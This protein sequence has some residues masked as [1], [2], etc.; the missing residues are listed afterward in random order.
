[1]SQL[2]N[3]HEQVFV[4]SARTEHDL[5][6]LAAPV[7][8]RVSCADG[9]SLRSIA[10]TLQLGREPLPYR[11]GTVS[12]DRESL[13]QALREVADGTA[14]VRL[15]DGAEGATASEPVT[16][17]Q[18]LS[19]WLDGAPVDW[20]TLWSQPRPDLATLPTY[21]R[22]GQRFWP[23]DQPA[24]AAG[25]APDP[26]RVDAG[27]AA[28]SA[29]G[30]SGAGALAGGGTV[31]KLLDERWDQAQ[32]PPVR[33]FDR[34]V[35]VIGDAAHTIAPSPTTLHIDPT[36]PLGHVGVRA[37]AA[38]TSDDF[39]QVFSQ[40]S[41]EY[42]AIDAVVV[43][44]AGVA[45]PVET[46]ARV[47]RIVD[48][49][50]RLTNG[51]NQVVL[52]T[53]GGDA[54]GAAAN[55]LVGAARSLRMSLPASRVRTVSVDAASVVGGDVSSLVASELS[56][57][58]ADVRWRSGDRY[59]PRFDIVQ[60]GAGERLPHGVHLVFGGAGVL[61]QALAERILADHADNV[62]VLVGRAPVAV[63]E[64]RVRRLVRDGRAH[65]LQADVSDTDTIGLLREH[66]TGC[67]GPVVGL[68]LLA[69]KESAGHLWESDL[70]EVH[71]VLA[72]KI[73]GLEAVETVFGGDDIEVRCAFGSSSAFFGDMGGGDYAFANRYLVERARTLSSPW[74]VVS[75]P[76]WAGGGMGPSD[77]DEMRMYLGAS[78]QVPLA[79]RQGLDLLVKLIGL[80]EGHV[81]VLVGQEKRL[82]ALVESVGGYVPAYAT[83]RAHIAEAVNSVDRTVNGTNDA[84]ANPPALTVAGNK[85]YSAKSER[86]NIA[87][88]EGVVSDV[89]AAVLGAPVQE[90]L[91]TA[92]FADLGF[93]SVALVELATALEK[94]VGVRVTPDVFFGHPTISRLAPRLIEMGAAFNG[95]AMSESESLNSASDDAEPVTHAP[96]SPA[97][98][99]ARASAATDLSTAGG[100]VFVVGGGVRVGGGVCGFG[101]V[102]D[103]LV[104]GGCV[105]GGLGG[106]RG[107][108][109]SGLGF[110]GV[111]GVCG[112]FV[113]G[114][115]GFDP[116]FFEI[117]PRE[118]VGM[119]PRQRLLLEVAWHA[120]EDSGLT[121][122]GLSGCRVGVFVGAEEGDFQYFGSG[123]S[124]TSNSNAVLASRLSYF[125]GFDGPVVAVNTA[126]SSGLVAV[127]QGARAV[128]LGE[129]DV[130]VVGGVNVLLA[131]F[132]YEA[133]VGAG[134]VSSSGVCRAFSAEA[135][136][137][138]PGEAVAVVVLASAGVVGRLGLS[139]RVEVVGSGV[140]YDGR[141]NGITAPSGRAQ[142]ELVG[143][144]WA[145]AGVDAGS[146]G[147]VVAHG[148]GTRLGD[149][150][151]LN[152]LVSVCA[153]VAGPGCLV[154]SSKP[155]FGHALAA[156]GVV[157]LVGLVESVRRGVVPGSL[158]VGQGDVNEFVR[159][160]E[161]RVRV[162][163]RVQGWPGDPVVRRGGVSA[164][165]M[166]GTNAH[167]LVQSVVEPAGWSGLGGVQVVVVSAK[168]RAALRRRCCDIAGWLRGIVRAGRE[169]GGSG[170]GLFGAGAWALLYRREHFSY[171]VAVVADDP[172]TAAD[173]LE[174]T[175][176]HPRRWAGRVGAGFAPDADG[177]AAVQR[178][179]RGMSEGVPGAAEEVAAW[180]VAGYAPVED[181]PQ[182]LPVLELPGYPFATDTYWPTSDSEQETRDTHAAGSAY[183]TNASTFEEVVF[184]LEVPRSAELLADHVVVGSPVLSATAVLAH[185]VEA[186]VAAFPLDVSGVRVESV[187][188]LKPLR[189]GA[190][191]VSARLRFEPDGSALVQKFEVRAPDASVVFATGRVQAAE[192]LTE[193]VDVAA[194]R[195]ECRARVAAEEIYAA[196]E[197]RGMEY[198][199]TL[200]GLSE[201][202][203]GAEVAVADVVMPY[204]GALSKA[205]RWAAAWD[206]GLQSVIAFELADAT[207][208]PVAR[209]PFHVESVEM[210]VG[211]QPPV[212]SVLR[213]R[214]FGGRSTSVDVDMCAASGEV[215]ARFRGFTTV[216]V[217]SR[218]PG[219]AASAGD[220][221]VLGHM[222]EERL[223]SKA[224]RDGATHSTRVSL[225]AGLSGDGDQDQ[226]FEVPAS[227]RAFAET[228]VRVAKVLTAA[229]TDADV[230]VLV[231]AGDDRLAGWAALAKSFAM[232]QPGVRVTVVEVSN[233][234]RPDRVNELASIVDHA[235]ETHVRLSGAGVSARRVALLDNELRDAH[236]GPF[237]VEGGVY[238]ITGGAGALGLEVAE[239]LAESATHVVLI[240]RR[241]RSELSE[242]ARER[243]ER[244]SGRL[245]YVSVEV[246][247]AS[248]M[249][250]LVAGVV[251]G[252]GR[253]DGVIHAAGVL[254]EG[255]L[256]AADHDSFAR[257]ISPKVDGL[258]AIEAA[259]RDLRDV[260]VIAFT[261][262]AGVF[263]G[264]GQSAYAVANAAV[265]ACVARMAENRPALSIAWPLWAGGGMS[266]DPRLV[267]RMR[268]RSGLA[269]LPVPTGLAVIERAWSLGVPNVVC[270]Y[271]DAAKIRE[272][273]SGSVANTRTS[274]VT[275]DGAAASLVNDAAPRAGARPLSEIAFDVLRDALAP[276]LG[277]PWHQFDREEKVEAYGLDSIRMMS[278]IDAL[279]KRLGTL[280]RTLFFEHRT[281]DGVVE[282]LAKLAPDRLR[283]IGQLPTP[284]VEAAPQVV[285][286]P[287]AAASRE[288][289]EPDAA[290]LA[291]PVPEPPG[292][293]ATS[294]ERGLVLVE[295]G[296]QHAS[297][298]VTPQGSQVGAIAIVGMAGRYPQAANLGAFWRNLIEGKDCVTRV[299]EDRW[300]LSHV[301]ESPEQVPDVRGGFLDGVYEFDP[302]LFRIS[303]RDALLMEPQ[304]R[305]F[306]ECAYSTIENAGY[307]PFG[308]AV[309]RPVGVFVGVMYEEYQMLGAERQLLGERA[310]FTNTT[311]SIANRV[312]YAFEFTGPSMA[313]DTMC[314]SSLTAIHLACESIQRGECEQ[315]IAGGV[316]VSVHPAKFIMLHEQRFASTRGR[317]SSFGQ[318][319]DGYVPSE[320]VGAVLLKPLDRALADGDR[321]LGVVRGTAIGHGGR[322]SGYT[323]PSPQAQAD[324]IE[325]ALSAA[326]VEPSEISAVE[327]HGTGTPLGDPIEVSGL[328]RV[329]GDSAEREAVLLG[330]VKSNIGHAE[331]A[332]GV[333]GVHKVL[334]EMQYATVVP[335]LHSGQLNTMIPFEQTPFVVPQEPVAWPTD[336]RRPRTA[337]VSAFGAGGANAHLVVS[338]YIDRREQAVV[339]GPFPVLV[340]A[341]T[342]GALRRRLRDLVG[343]LDDD[344]NLGAVAATLATGRDSFPH[345]FGAVVATVAELRAAVEAA[346]EQTPRGGFAVTPDDAPAPGASQADEV[347]DLASQVAAWTKG[348]PQPRAA[349]Q[350]EQ[351]IRIELPAYPFEA[352]VYAP[353]P[354]DR[355]AFAT[356]T[357]GDGQPLHPL[358]HRN[359]STVEEVA[360]ASELEHGTPG[361]MAGGV[362]T[363]AAVLEIA[364]AATQFGGSLVSG[365]LVLES[366]EWGEPVPGEHMRVT[367]RR[368]GRDVEWEV[369][370]PGTDEIHARGRAAVRHEPH[371]DVE[372][373]GWAE[374]LLTA[375]PNGASDGTASHRVGPF[376]LLV[377]PAEGR[378]AGVMDPVFL[379]EAVEIARRDLDW[380]ASGTAVPVRAWFASD[381]APTHTVLAESLDEAAPRPRETA[382]RARALRVIGIDEAGHVTWEVLLR[383][384]QAV[385]E[386]PERVPAS[387][388]DTITQPTGQ[389]GKGTRPEVALYTEEWVTV[390]AAKGDDA[391]VIVLVTTRDDGVE[392]ADH[393]RLIRGE[394]ASSVVVSLAPEATGNVG[395]T[396]AHAGTLADRFEAV[397][398]EYGPIAGV[399]IVLREPDF[400]DPSAVQAVVN[401]LGTRTIR[402]SRACLLCWTPENPVSTPDAEAWI[403]VTRSLRMTLPATRISVVLD[404]GVSIRQA[405]AA[406]INELGS[407][408]P[409]DVLIDDT[410]TRRVL[411]L[412]AAPA[413]P[414]SSATLTG[415]YLITGGAGG[416]GRQVA[417]ELL[418]GGA[419][420]V[421]LTGRAAPETRSDVLNALR[422]VATS[423]NAV[424]E[425]TQ[426]DVTD[427]HAVRDEI[428][429]I[430]SVHGP[431]DGILHAA[432][433]ESEGR[434]AQ[435]SPEQIEAVMAPK[436][437]GTK[438]LASALRAHDDTFLCL[439]SSTSAQLGDF[440]SGD[441]AAANRWLVAEARRL[442]REGV[443]ATAVCWPLWRSDGMNLPSQE[444]TSMYLAASGQ[445]LLGADDAVAALRSVVSLNHPSVVVMCGERDRFEQFLPLSDD[446]PPRS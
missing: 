436:R 229:G 294:D 119:D 33:V 222:V 274:A 290:P 38:L 305:L 344:A 194:T 21:P 415:R 404:G 148:T 354:I 118:A 209:V 124:V 129:C 335:S 408:T 126:C 331:S 383:G 35:V 311:A 59:L 90:I 417:E 47:G 359:V 57:D 79:I 81:L 156:S 84:A 441:Y 30:E 293:T 276:E 370:Q 66:V 87:A 324:V 121:V 56:V 263:G 61:G 414:A 316:N 430:T 34:P 299:P 253:L 26:S 102:W 265:D 372:V 397:Q 112:G 333:A 136:G 178:A 32:R 142:A 426:V 347:S 396:N 295:G 403:G 317:C 211:A 183:L 51:V 268:R 83:S 94:R 330:S 163:D 82:D 63:G 389:A 255:L 154:T 206:A 89:I 103:V 143:S 74:L 207:E 128:A 165:G 369:G 329:F 24:P 244:A 416:V 27:S 28:A 9:P 225:L 147:H 272:T 262:I 205:G 152:A 224:Q 241:S 134:M 130:A 97:Q 273:W 75:W 289:L 164:F 385:P 326:G 245:S 258:H 434:F 218:Q 280:P 216:P 393:L 257:A 78:G 212:V 22:G 100:G 345:R 221:V 105:V 328:S 440:G 427:A 54:T 429:R 44:E 50:R 185:V 368:R 223:P 17:A 174:A 278:V 150:V 234:V 309:G 195:E 362:L 48:A 379:T 198:G 407:E 158:G 432:G 312:S 314:S 213:R 360:F 356:V 175:A 109:W 145:G 406:A 315:A 361:V 162:S 386:P 92:N 357:S 279:E 322:T 399:V 363:D 319:G 42:G 111:D 264:V 153:G 410:R 348:G 77:E 176:G 138:V 267:E 157:S 236:R 413:T 334:L 116:L 180:F 392:A 217:E 120:L 327:A 196:Y 36:R 220:T 201:V 336:P 287:Q 424:V 422:A 269:P 445:A 365:D 192:A 283:E 1:M 23:S 98:E 285:E 307:A 18:A 52:L 243:L 101:G 62:V 442:R 16:A 419:S 282:H 400:T 72:A 202:C 179:A 240:G 401:A 227:S 123:V 320:G 425:Y 308:F 435:R 439:F 5:R 351:F 25:A 20:D 346:L 284:E 338:E 412:T 58:D 19:A 418:R 64:Q 235:R 277:V 3:T 41:E 409:D 313:V 304:E 391:G 388:V 380:D 172:C 250:G 446:E 411:R 286:A 239:W 166:S 29:S 438:A 349:D 177:Q 302:L 219:A 431:L 37:Y 132:A 231:P 67:F 146:V 402:V 151:E 230:E 85:G 433:V 191:G 173:L 437:L 394:H 155:N 249:S 80:S 371:P 443:R 341:Q 6:Q 181:D 167:V 266:M 70:A 390:P 306:L 366:L 131:P 373:T 53:R 395:V 247:D 76:L 190:D 31:V 68:Y 378:F 189:A 169:S 149:P 199:P 387:P 405:Y 382:P 214:D 275:I 251:A 10:Y 73:E 281:L 104:G 140:N 11:W 55:S 133:M 2:E 364:R 352:E 291:E 297:S 353:S 208:E 298:T 256:P 159:W 375:A 137:L 271:G 125:L 110:D 168:T 237:R 337:G 187:T 93:D 420:V 376:T 43:D 197:R 350:Q 332:A 228:T 96:A 210:A 318:E 99:T 45:E 114:V 161:A 270:G 141:T 13:A 127:H 260:P 343:W 7:A 215:V 444:S 301:Y 170:G 259:L 325:R 115:G 292:V 49:L 106:W 296:V 88:L 12:G 261:S 60:A 323:V 226:S 377:R 160:D 186:A 254:E 108:L 15:A 122:G 310:A 340:S 242:A 303:P 4:L 40:I 46:L 91:R 65:Y 300:D 238:L 339:E 139:A 8:Q 117:S 39:V 193:V 381:P 367:L 288:E 384:E 171:R 246:V 113:E 188:W 203:A 71:A 358:V 107:G 423:C 421:V 248:A 69:G 321:I 14:T 233:D 428:A 200:R 182:P 342:D 374:T 86:E 204:A 398:E 232:E 144:V 95:T 135:D 252:R 355:A 184:D